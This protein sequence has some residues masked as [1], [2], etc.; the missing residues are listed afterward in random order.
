MA[1]DSSPT[2]R[3]RRLASELRRLREQVA[4]LTIEQAAGQ[5]GW[6]KSKLSRIETGRTRAKP[7]EV[8]IA[9]ELY[10]GTTAEERAELI[11]LARDAQKRGWWRQYPDVF[12]GAFV[13]LESGAKRIRKWETQLVP[14]LLQTGDYARAVIRSGLPDKDEADVQRRVQ[15]RMMRKELLSRPAA[16]S[17]HVILDEAVLHRPIG[18]H[19]VMRGQLREVLATAERPNVTIQVL[20]FEAGAH[21]GLEGPFVVLSFPEKV[22]PDVVYTEV[23]A[24]DI[25]LESADEVARFNLA[26]E[27]L[28][29][30]A[31][32]PQESAKLIADVIN[33]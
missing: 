17:L 16:P 28:R 13:G 33:K 14:G 9:L 11:E 10:G 18:G 12:T 29:N 25:Y 15:G 19:E 31:L 7:A 2:T 26:F 6:S 30:A 8:G 1:S 4:R 21:A 24:G 3:G 27:R 23:M 20:P 22:D 32:D 5:L